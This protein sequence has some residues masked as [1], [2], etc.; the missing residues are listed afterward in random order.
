MKW[1]MFAAGMAAGAILI[2]LIQQFVLQ[3]SISPV[4]SPDGGERILSLIDG[5][6]NSLDIEV[7]VFTSKNVVQALER[8]KARGVAVRIIVERNVMGGQNDATYRQLASE[9]FNIRYAR[10]DVAL[11]HSKFIIVDGTAVLVGSHNFSNSALYENREASVIIRDIATV[12]SFDDVFE[13]DWRL[14]D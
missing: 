9:G 8:A 11:T 7:Y 14:A 12:A 3:P 1:G 2:L 13:E 5:A 6:Q 10:T 4:F